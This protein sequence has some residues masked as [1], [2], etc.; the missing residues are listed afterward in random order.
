MQYREVS[1]NKLSDVM[2]EIPRSGGMRG[3]GLI[4]ASE[5]M[6]GDILKDEAVRQVMNVAYLPGILRYSI[7]MPDIHWGYGFPI[8]G[9]GG[10][11]PGRGGNSPRGGGGDDK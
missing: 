5:A 3:P 7:G 6:M 2:W 11:D 10:V 1:L 9:G 8:G 4:F